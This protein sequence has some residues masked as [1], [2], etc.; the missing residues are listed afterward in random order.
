VKEIH[1]NYA[2]EGFVSDVRGPRRIPNGS[3][4]I[5]LSLVLDELF[6]VHPEHQHN[7]SRTKRQGLHESKADLFRELQRN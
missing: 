2:N 3:I 5:H 6:I 1:A 7:G 4:H